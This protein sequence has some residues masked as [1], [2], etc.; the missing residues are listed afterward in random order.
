MYRLGVR[1]KDFGE[2]HG[3]R[4]WAGPV[5]RLGKAVRDWAAQRVFLQPG[6][7]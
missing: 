1:I 5:I 7:D 3:R 2:R 6:R 4:W